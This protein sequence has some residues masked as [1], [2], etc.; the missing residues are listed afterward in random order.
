MFP[1]GAWK[2]FEMK[3]EFGNGDDKPLDSCLGRFGAP[4]HFNSCFPHL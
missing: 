1:K 4:C 2:T 3:A